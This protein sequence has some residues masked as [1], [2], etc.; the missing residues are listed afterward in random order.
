MPS[1]IPIKAGGHRPAAPAKSTS[2]TTRS[3]RATEQSP[4]A[5]LRLPTTHVPASTAEAGHRLLSTSIRP[6]L[7]SL[8]P[9]DEYLSHHDTK[10]LATGGPNPQAAS[11]LFRARQGVLLFG[12]FRNADLAND[13][14]AREGLVQAIRRETVP[15]PE[16]AVV[17]LAPD[18]ALAAMTHRDWQTA[19]ALAPL[20]VDIAE[21]KHCL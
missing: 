1:L 5:G 2:R 20:Q 12:D 11:A 9:P 16:T 19:A 15:L 6:A 14:S 21:A 17:T 3:D 13:A 4:A 18:E 7:H 8:Q 10:R